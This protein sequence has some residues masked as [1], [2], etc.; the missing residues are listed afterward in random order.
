MQRAALDLIAEHGTTN[1]H[2]VVRRAR[3]D[4]EH[5]ATH[6][7]LVSARRAI[8]AVRAPRFPGEPTRPPR[9]VSVALLAEPEPLGWCANCGHDRGSAGHREACG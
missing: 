4:E 9:G 7:E 1:T 6:A 3:G 5:T 2:A 8:A